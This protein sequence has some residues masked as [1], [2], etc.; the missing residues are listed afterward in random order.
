MLFKTEEKAVQSVKQIK[1]EK[2]NKD[3]Y[4]DDWDHVPSGGYDKWE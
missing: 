2:R 1:K 4:F 3:D